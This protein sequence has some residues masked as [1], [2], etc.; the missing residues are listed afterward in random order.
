[1]RVGKTLIWVDP[2]DIIP[3]HFTLSSARLSLRGS[4]NLSTRGTIRDVV[5]IPANKEAI[6]QNVVALNFD[7]GRMI[8]SELTSADTYDNIRKL[9]PILL[10]HSISGRVFDS[11]HGFVTIE[12]LADLRFVT[13]TQLFPSGGE[14]I[15]TG[16]NNRR[17]QLVA[18]SDT[19][20]TLGLDLDGAVGF[21]RRVSLA[22]TD[23][24]GPIGSDLRDTDH[25]GMHN[26]WET[27]FGLDPNNT[28]ADADADP[29]DDGFTNSA[30]YVG[31]GN[32]R[33]SG[34]KPALV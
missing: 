5:D 2:N 7:T 30:E 25:D 24:T 32:P 20:V 1:M 16:A 23:L 29:D 10:T 11:T 19:R 33:L 9:T 6:T 12:T 8:K 26:S 22:W 27:A 4:V 28:P 14:V 17:I 31:G 34:S 18:N 13:A 3:T 21:E 15:L